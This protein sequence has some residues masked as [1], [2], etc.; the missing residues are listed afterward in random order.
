MH[1]S[2]T[3][4]AVIIRALG[5]DRV[6]DALDSLARQTSRAFEAVLVDMSP[7]TLDSVVAVV[8]PV[9]PGLVHLKIGRR[10]SRAHALNTGIGASSAAAISI[11][12][13]DNL[14]GPGHVRTLLAGLAE[15]GADLVYTPVRRQ[16]LTPDG[17]LIGEE[18]HRAAFSRPRLLFGN[19]IFATGTA[20][21]RHIWRRVGGYDRRFQVYEDWEFLIRVAHAGRI[22]A[23]EGD[24][25]IVR[26]FTGDAGVFSHNRELTDCLRS[27]AGLFWKHRRR[28]SDALFDEHPELAID[29]P[30]V[31]RGGYRAGSAKMLMQWYWDH[32]RRMATFS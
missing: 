1:T 2:P 10:L 30:D 18:R 22:A 32:V 29:N 6:G 7:G 14:Y 19:Y 28:Y 21:T 12:D 17:V 24:E 13:D 15:T 31:P 5:P 9:L 4:L 26:N 25:A 11:L 20:F 8:A 23:I 27:T 3:K 16:T